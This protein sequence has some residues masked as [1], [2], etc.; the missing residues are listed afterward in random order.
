MTTLFALLG[1]NV[2]G[3]ETSTSAVRR[4]QVEIH[5][6]PIRSKVILTHYDG[7]LS[8][9]AALNNQ[10]FD[11]VFSKS[12]LVAVG[13]ALP[14]FLGDLAKLLAPEGRCIFVE[15][16]YAGGIF[17]LLRA[18]RRRWRGRQRY[19]NLGSTHLE[20]ISQVFDIT[21]I[22]RSYLP[23]IY[24]IMGKKRTFSTSEKAPVNPALN[25]GLTT[26]RIEE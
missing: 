9:C 1:A 13:N 14:Q 23:P 3:V 26:P 18:L 11:I 12:V 7:K 16:A 24:L 5:S 22:R 19:D 6:R 10:Q 15:N 20:L 8:H 25:N 21:E 17:A 2:T 4:A